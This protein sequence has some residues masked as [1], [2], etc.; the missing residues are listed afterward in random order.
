MLS[1]MFNIILI[2]LLIAMFLAV[3]MGGSGTAP[4]FSAAYGANLIRR[5]AIPGLFGIFV[6]LGAII[7]GKA[8]A[9][10]VGKGLMPAD[11]MTLTITSIVLLSVALALL[12]ANLLAIP[13][14]TSQATIFALMGPAIYFDVLNTQKLFMEII[15]TW[16]I[17]PLVSFFIVFLIGKYIYQ[18]VR[19]MK[20]VNKYVKYD[21]IAN[22]PGLKFFIVLGSLYVAFSIGSNN[23]ANASGPIASMILNEMSMDPSHSNFLIIMILS[24]LIIAPCFGI[25]SSIFGHKVVTSAGKEI[26]EFGPLG[27]LAISVISATLLLLASVTKGIPTSLVQLNTGA[28][29]ALGVVKMG[30]KNTFR[31]KIVE[32]FWLIWI[33][34]P[35][36]SFLLAL[37]FTIIADGLGILHY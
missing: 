31:Q 24:T 29:L 11:Y 22:H 4:A 36:I 33:V 20:F 2:P 19:K 25:G 13:Q 9:T 27:G 5:D 32:R 12:F 18:P 16:F 15:P 14:S 28:I 3:N 21:H 26:V 1:P 6:F 30:W 35:I 17:L 37:L 7:A 23:V 34:S 8:V 10:T